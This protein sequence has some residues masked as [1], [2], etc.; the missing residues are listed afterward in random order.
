MNDPLRALLQAG[1]PLPP[2]EEIAPADARRM[3]QTVLAE[4]PSSTLW[5]RWPV[6]AV[7]V[8]LIS[9][10]A[11]G[12]FLNPRPRPDLGSESGITV[13]SAGPETPSLTDLPEE[14]RAR[15]IRFMTRGG[16]RVIWTLEPPTPTATTTP[17]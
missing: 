11:S 1:D 13:A 16:T 7:A 15:Q 12:A 6:A 3:R 2:G 14:P 17:R 4:T 5:H 9:V 8:T 10:I